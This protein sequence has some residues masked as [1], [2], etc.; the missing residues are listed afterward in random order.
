MRINMPISYKAFLW[1]APVF[2]IAVLVFAMGIDRHFRVHA[3]GYVLFGLGILGALLG[4]VMHVGIVQLFLKCPICGSFGELSF[5]YQNGYTE[6]R[7]LFDCPHCKRLVNKSSRLVSV[8]KEN[9]AVCPDCGFEYAEGE[10]ICPYC[11]KK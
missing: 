4:T 3:F 11:S 1:G 2:T 6:A 9:E 7:S 5:G 10:S 8:E